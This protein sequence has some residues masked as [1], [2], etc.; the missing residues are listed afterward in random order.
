MIKTHKNTF[1]R[2]YL[3]VCLSEGLIYTSGEKYPQDETD[4]VSMA[5][6][7]TI[8]KDMFPGPLH[9]IFYVK[10][11]VLHLLQQCG[12]IKKIEFN[13][14]AMAVVDPH[15]SYEYTTEN[16]G[17]SRGVAVFMED[18]SLRVCKLDK[19]P[20]TV[21]RLSADKFIETRNF[22]LKN[23]CSYL[24]TSYLR[25]LLPQT[26]MVKCISHKSHIFSLCGDGTL[27]KI[28]GPNRSLDGLYARLDLSS[29]DVVEEDVLDIMEVR[30]SVRII[31]IVIK[32][33]EVKA[34]Y[35]TG[36]PCKVPDIDFNFESDNLPL[37]FCTSR[38]KSAR[39]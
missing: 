20:N 36:T 12:H 18:G 29:G 26:P 28:K 9:F 6:I 13:C 1:Y 33:N 31:M 4:I 24:T 27:Y 14:N 3:E 5:V 19:E 30:V 11:G 37:L 10:D 21:V 22:S 7:T 8:R 25:K 34:Y 35:K 23:T 32:H 39:K 16:Y 15:F 2:G 38:A 17:W